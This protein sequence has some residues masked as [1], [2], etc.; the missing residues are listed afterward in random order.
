[1]TKKILIG[2]GILAG[3]GLVYYLWKKN[4]EEKTSSAD[5]CGCGCSGDSGSSNRTFRI[6]NI[7]DNPM[8]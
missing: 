8:K 7:R 1:M 6:K 5:G 4:K 2:A 3:A